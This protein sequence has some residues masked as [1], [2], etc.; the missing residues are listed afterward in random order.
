MR[1][2]LL[3]EI[4]S[5]PTE[6]LAVLYFD[7]NGNLIESK[8][9]NTASNIS[10]IK[11]TGVHPNGTLIGLINVD[12]T[13]G[14]NTVSTVQTFVLD[15]LNYQCLFTPATTVPVNTSISFASKNITNNSLSVLE[16][17]HFTF[18]E[19]SPGRII[20]CVQE[21]VQT[22]E[23]IDNVIARTLWENHDKQFNTSVEVLSAISKVSV[24]PNPSK[25]IFNL[26][27]EHPNE[28]QQ[29]S[30][31]SSVGQEVYSTA[32][33]NQTNY[34]LDTQLDKGVYILLLN[35]EAVQK[36]IIE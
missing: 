8:I 25:G 6:R 3:G 29:I 16:V 19:A 17:K 2:L 13:I 28:T 1:L 33:S 35:G 21:G 7:E 31:L 15:K 26:N 30:I 9:Q 32:I 11:Y 5:N 23:E 36:L 20:E 34:T 24:Y 27:F 12:K 14:N 18:D 22:Q 4:K 10:R